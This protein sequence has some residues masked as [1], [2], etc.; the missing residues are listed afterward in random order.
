[1]DLD[2]KNI[3]LQFEGF[4]KTPSLWKNDDIFDLQQ[5]QFKNTSTSTFEGEIP[6]YL[7]LGKRVER[8]V[9]HELKQDTSITILAEKYWNTFI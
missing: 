1:M 4:C 6:K 3:Q 9:A 5:F 8:F 2:S 7:R